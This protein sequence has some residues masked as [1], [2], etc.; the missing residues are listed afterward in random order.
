MPT[1][2]LYRSKTEKMIAGV[3]GGLGEY[4]SIDP[5]LVRL[6]FAI[7]A[8]LGGPGVIIYLIMWIVVPVRPTDQIV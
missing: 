8:I 2:K 4:F 6:L 3:C 1:H 7:G 5:T